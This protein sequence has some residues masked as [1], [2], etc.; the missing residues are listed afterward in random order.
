MG[1]CHDGRNTG[2][3]DHEQCFLQQEQKICMFCTRLF[4]K[5]LISLVVFIVTRQTVSVSWGLGFCLIKSSTVWAIVRISLMEF[6]WNQKPRRLGLRWS[7]I[8]M[9][10]HRNRNSGVRS[11]FCLAHLVVLTGPVLR[12]RTW[13]PI[14]LSLWVTVIWPIA[15][16]RNVD[17]IKWLLSWRAPSCEVIEPL[18]LFNSKF[19]FII[20]MGWTTDERHGTALAISSAREL[21]TYFEPNTPCE[22]AI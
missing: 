7:R 6:K 19:E 3:V 1:Q 9:K 20:I 10:M 5:S 8:I 12:R 15:S 13:V 16:K 21:M 2:G 11:L 14:S 4:L 18:S 22:I 17:K